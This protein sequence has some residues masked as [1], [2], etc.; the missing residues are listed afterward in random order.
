MDKIILGNWKMNG[1]LKMIENYFSELKS[2][3]LSVKK[4][5]VG[6]AVPF[7]YLSLFQ[8]YL[9]Q[10]SWMLGAQDVSQFM[11]QGAYTGEVSVEMLKDFNTQ[12]ALVG[13]SER[14]QYFK[15][16]N[17]LLTRKIK[18]LLSGNIIP[19]FCVGEILEEKESQHTEQ[20]LNEQLNAL[21]NEIDT[22]NIVIAYEP[23]WAIG[24]GKIPTQEE[25]YTSLKYIRSQI[26]SRHSE[27]DKIPLLYGGSVSGDN[28]KEIISI[29][30][31]DGL[32]I[33][34]AS[35]KPHDFIK[36]VQSV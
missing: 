33:G 35:L 28:A 26:L 29:E 14:R 18:N 6:L 34:G 22:K 31:V 24:T 25:I 12:F 5:T 8:K 20:V 10:S 21:D 3:S 9:K 17:A 30:H 2:E 27:A 1:S 11:E 19:I 32:L 15:E 23:V 16:S 4:H 36:I 7:P 13:H